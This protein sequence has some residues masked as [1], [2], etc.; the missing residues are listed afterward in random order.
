VAQKDVIV[1]N[2][3]VQDPTEIPGIEAVETLL[4]SGGHEISISR[5]KDVALMAMKCWDN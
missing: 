2:E 5:G 4:L 1:G 3:C